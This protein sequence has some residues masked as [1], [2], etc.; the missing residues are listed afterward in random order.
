MLL[1]GIE[2]QREVRSLVSPFAAPGETQAQDCGK[3]LV[4]SPG[5]VF[6]VSPRVFVFGRLAAASLYL[7]D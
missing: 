1:S 7:Y 5:G 3:A 4:A 2:S 6:L